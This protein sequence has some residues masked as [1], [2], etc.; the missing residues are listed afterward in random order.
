MPEEK[1]QEPWC[2]PW[3]AGLNSEAKSVARKLSTLLNALADI[4]SGVIKGTLANELWQYRVDLHTRLKAE[5]WRIT[6]KDQ[7]GWKVLPPLRKRQ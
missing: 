2:E 1:K 4:D 6:P 5:G 7:S 3:E